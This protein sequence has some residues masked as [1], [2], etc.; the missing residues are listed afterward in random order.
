MY[1]WTHGVLRSILKSKTRFGQYVLFAIRSC[2]GH[3]AEPTTALFP[4][5]LLLDDAGLSRPQ[6]LGKSRRERLARRRALNLVVAALNYLYS[7]SPFSSLPGLRRR[8][9]A[10]HVSIYERLLVLI[11]AGGPTGFFSSIGCGRKFHQLDARLTELLGALQSLG[12][13]D[14]HAYT[15]RAA[16]ADQSLPSMTRTSLCL[17]EALTLAD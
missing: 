10:L 15:D 11:R 7:S 17:I 16:A 5:P 4:I 6:R 12:I 9:S 2:R 1:A 13:S 8:P 3:R 14:Q